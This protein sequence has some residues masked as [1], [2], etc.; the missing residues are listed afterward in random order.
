MRPL[1]IVLLLLSLHTVSTVAANNTTTATNT[2][3]STNTTKS[4]GTA[5]N[6]PSPIPAALQTDD[7][8]GQV[9]TLKQTESSQAYPSLKQCYIFTRDACC[10]S[11]HDQVIQQNLTNLVSSSCVEQFDDLIQYFCFGCHKQQA[12]YF[13]KTS[14]KVR[15]CKDFA[16][17]VWTGGSQDTSKLTQTQ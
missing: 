17:R 13:N 3:T 7:S 1:K 4:N 16:T 12:Q 6:S 8:L 9:C 14:R 2:S 10:T 11:S 5:N 15:I